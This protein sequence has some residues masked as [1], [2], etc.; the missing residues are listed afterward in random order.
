MIGTAIGIA[1]VII[2]FAVILIKSEIKYSKNQAKQKR[3]AAIRESSSDSEDKVETLTTRQKQ[4][5]EKFGDNEV[6]EGN[7]A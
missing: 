6:S 5:A 3:M 1:I 7:V 2:T 4:R